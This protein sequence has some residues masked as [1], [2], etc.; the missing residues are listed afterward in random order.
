MRNISNLLLNRAAAR[1]REVATRRALGAGSG[2]LVGQFLTEGLLLTTAGALAGLGV[3]VLGAK[4][5][6]ALAPSRVPLQSEIGLDLRV[7]AFTLVVSTL[8]ALVFG[9][10]PLLE[11]GRDHLVTA[12]R[13]G[14][15]SGSAGP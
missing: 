4:G 10:A 13:E 14:G 9:L 11:V 3:A 5:L 6:L 12:L 1:S 8:T 7:L 2:R 15:R